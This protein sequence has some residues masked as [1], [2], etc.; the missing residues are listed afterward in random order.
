VAGG[1]WLDEI[2]ATEAGSEQL[3]RALVEQVPAVVY[4]ETNEFHSR[5]LY[6]SPQVGWMFGRA[7]DEWIADPDLWWNC[8]HA[9]DRALVDAEWAECLR[10]GDPFALDY[11]IV[12]PDGTPIWT[13]DTAVP[14]RD[15]RDRIIY[16]EGVMYDITASKT[17]ED[18]LRGSEARYRALIENIP[19]VVYMVAPDDD[20]KTLYVSPQIEIALGYSR[21]EWLEQPDIWM[22]LL[23]PDDREPT[24]AAHDLHNEAGRPWSREYRLIASD[25]RPIWFRDVATLVRDPGGRPL[26]WQGVQLDITELKRAEEELR[27]ARDELELRVLERTHE[28]EEA[29]ELMMLEIDERRRVERELRETQERFRMLAERIPGVT[30]VWRVRHK[31][32][33]PV[34]VSPQVEA[35]L[36]FRADEWGSEELWVS[37]LHP[38][39]RD[40]VLDA[41]RRS[42]TTGEPFSMEYRYLAKDGHVVWVVDE[43]ILIE[44]D[45]VGRPKTFHGVMVDVT[46]RRDAEAKAVENELRYRTLAAQIPAITYLWTRTADDAPHGRTR[47]VSPQVETVL[48]F[49]P[50]RWTSEPDFWITRLHPADRE[51]VVATAGRGTETGQPFSMEYRLIAAD[52]RVVWI[53]DEG[54]V[55]ARDERGRPLEWQG[56]MLD[57]TEHERAQ[58]ERRSAEARLRAV[59][60]Q[61]PAIVYAET[62]PSPDG[63]ARLVYISPQ[64]EAILGY[65]PDELLRDVDHLASLVHPD[66]R[67]RVIAANDAALRDIAAFDE[68]Y[69]VFAKDGRVVW[70]HSRASPVSAEADEGLFWQ[71]VAL[72]VTDR[73]RLSDAVRDL[74]ARVGAESRPRVAG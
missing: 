55:I 19:A 12:A 69:R 70:L 21:R 23:H 38:D 26:H 51:R 31:R 22:E 58:H 63:P 46:A 9:D 37:R 59:V 14:I 7:P 61:V 62:A 73:H 66:D 54:R 30:Y 34:Y 20:R 5:T 36:G 53:R 67:D 74:E 1:G 50:E 52:G 32:E 49:T 27:D 16:W 3:Y 56:I 11:R 33:E 13:R 4:V 39:D 41:T 15:E 42:A 35:M 47:Y 48:G 43:A 8:T 72:D 60:E 18:E 10:T 71:G 64:V 2:F 24:L 40:D 29:N 17:A 45:D 68:E 44:R 28:L 25:G 6:L 57:V 65:R